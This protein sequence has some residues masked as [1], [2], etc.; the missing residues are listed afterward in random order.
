MGLPTALN[1]SLRL[2]DS[3]LD[4]AGEVGAAIMLEFSNGGRA[5]IFDR[6]NG[7]GELRATFSAVGKNGALRGRFGLWTNYP[8]GEDDRIVYAPC[9]SFD[10]WQPVAVNGRWIPDAFQGPMEELVRAVRGGPSPTT[11]GAQHLRTLE[12]VDAVYESARR[13][14]RLEFD[15]GA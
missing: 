1:A 10:A 2:R 3:H 8:E 14:C 9:D 11:T 13:G 12:L 7:L 5:W 6:F 4:V 15:N